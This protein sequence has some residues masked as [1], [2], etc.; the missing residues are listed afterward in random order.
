M[1]TRDY[2]GPLG[3]LKDG[4]KHPSENKLIECLDDLYEEGKK[5][6]DR[7]LPPK[8]L[9]EDR[10]LYRGDWAKASGKEPYFDANFI[11][12]FIDR[13][14]AQLTDNRPVLR[15]EHRKAGLKKLAQTTQKVTTAVW[16]ECKMQRQ[17]YKM[18]HTAG[19]NAC[20]G[21][22]TGHDSEHDDV[23]LEMLRL[24]Q[25]VMDPMVKEA[26]LLEKA[27]YLFVD[28]VQPLSLIRQR[29]PGRGAFVK[30][31]A[32]ISE[33]PEEAKRRTVLSPLTDLLSGK[34]DSQDALERA[35]IRECFIMDRQRAPDG[36][37]L[38]PN[39]RRIVKCQDYVLWDGPYAYW[40]GVWPVDLF[41][42]AVDP[43]HP[44]GMSAVKLLKRLQLS[45][46][47]LMDGTV[48]NHIISNIIS[49]IMDADAL[50]P[51]S[52]KVLQKLQSTL[53]LRKQNRNSNVTI[54][55]P[56]VFG[57]DKVA[58][59]KQVFSIAQLLTGVTD[60]TLGENPGSLQ[61]GQAVEGLQEGANLM[62]RSRAS[63]LEDFM[64]RVGQKL[65]ARVYQWWP[66]ERVMHLV[67][68]TG[69]AMEYAFKR[70]EFFVNDDGSPMTP[71]ERRDVFKYV[72]FRVQPGT[73]APGSKLRRTELMMRLFGSGLAT[74]EDV[75]ETAEFPDAAA[76]AAKAMEEASKRDPK[77][78]EKMRQSLGK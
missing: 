29:F 31:D 9:E 58:I 35:N 27:E 49:V 42:W 41:D 12:A 23:E 78:A 68:P 75:L 3:E 51:E 65:I 14:T 34:R 33:N 7:Y 47:Q 50:Q 13:M 40:D 16:E 62:T 77:L 32:N 22:Y 66:S 18:C 45:F 28:R 26:A 25:I 76:R 70:T 72:R 24:S 6:R 4:R 54:T 74:G 30:A 60:V 53:V 11:Q 2:P 39:G 61:S 19:I 5:V 56:P 63:R 48:E 59:A 55:P 8:Q 46:N 21:I 38:F 15:I 43:D 17:L 67:G 20:A 64:G 37:R 57:A 73:S 10:K 52:Q 44:F 71:Q 36:T 1:A 69:E